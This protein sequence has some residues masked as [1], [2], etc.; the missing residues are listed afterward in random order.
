MQ[1][2]MLMITPVWKPAILYQEEA[3]MKRKEYLYSEENWK[4][5][6]SIGKYIIFVS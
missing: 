5:Q 6:L 4:F 3:Y 2:F 1:D